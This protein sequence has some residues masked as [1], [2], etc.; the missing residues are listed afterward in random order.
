MRFKEINFFIILLIAASI[1]L[2][3]YFL[4]F[5]QRIENTNE[6]VENIPKI[7]TF[8]SYPENF[9][10]KIT[11]LAKLYS[12]KEITI[13]AEVDGTIKEK[14]FSIGSMVKKGDVIIAM[15]DTRKLLQ[16][17]EVK[18]GLSAFKAILDEESKNYKDAISLYDKDIISRSELKSKENL[19]K[20]AKSEYDNK[21]AIYKRILWEFDNLNVKAPFDGYINKFY[22][23]VGQKINSG[24]S[25]LQFSNYDKLIGRV[26]LNSEDLKKIDSSDK[27]INVIDSS[28]PTEVKFLGLSKEIN[29]EIFS[30]LLEFQIDNSE[31]KF[32]PGEVVEVELNI[33]EY[34]NYFIFPAKAVLNQGNDF[35]IFYYDNGIA[36]KEYITPIWIDDQNCAIEN[37]M[38]LS[39][40]NIILNG[41]FNLEDGQP[42]EILNENY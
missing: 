12:E 31:E 8:I 28:G 15:T 14:K 35:Y 4:Q 16:L 34:N 37:S 2:G 33:E 22:F 42:V 27:K 5:S 41:Q 29:K 13:N 6:N 21:E 39:E 9:T 17:K 25:L 10:K 24:Q 3:L 36:F 7:S 26:S 32:L 40:I 19:Y 38:E 11:V 18:D 20:K 23:D 1:L 30:Y